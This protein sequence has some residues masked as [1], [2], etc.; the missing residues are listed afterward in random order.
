YGRFL[1][2]MS[3]HAAG[4]EQLK[5]EIKNHP[6]HAMARLEIAAAYYKVNS[7]AGLPYAEEAVKLD[8]SGPLGHYLLGVLLLDT[9]DYLRAIPELEVAQK[10]FPQ[11]AKIYLALGAAYSRAGRD[12]DAARARKEFQRLEREPKRDSEL[13]GTR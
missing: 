8:P 6:N 1:L 10:A 4:L 3:D 9:D 5:Q 12:A 11:E 7:A 13:P 2:E